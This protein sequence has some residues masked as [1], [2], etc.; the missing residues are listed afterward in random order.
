MV[1]RKI[2]N[3]G[4]PLLSPDGAIIKNTTVAFLLIDENGKPTDVFDAITGERISGVVYTKTDEHGE[5]EV[6]LFPNSRGSK[7][8]AYLVRVLKEGVEDIIASLQEGINPIPWMEFKYAGVPITPA[9]M[10]LFQEFIDNAINDGLVSLLSTWSSHKINDEIADIV[11]DLNILT[12]IAT[13][14]Y[15]FVIASPLAEWEITHNLN[16]PVVAITYTEDNQLVEGEVYM[17]SLNKIKIV[18][19]MPISGIAYVK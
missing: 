16:R 13:P 15:E 4:Q 18:F 2:N 19:S 7:T 11:N 3:I 10:N 5:F 14:Y 6:S 12:S 8:T 17:I 1:T 9:D